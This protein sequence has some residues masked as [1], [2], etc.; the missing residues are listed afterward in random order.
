MK[1]FITRRSALQEIKKSPSGIR[2]MIPD[3]SLELH[4]EMKA[5]EMIFTWAIMKDFILLKSPLQII[6]YVK[7]KIMFC[8][9]F[10]I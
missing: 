5:P 8:H 10:N 7:Q 2:K 3:G 4:K 9:M 1:E 6:D